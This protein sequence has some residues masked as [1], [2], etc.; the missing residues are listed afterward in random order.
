MYRQ[1]L[2]KQIKSKRKRFRKS[3]T[4]RYFENEGENEA[5]KER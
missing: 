5:K 2:S 4:K 1:N 3:K